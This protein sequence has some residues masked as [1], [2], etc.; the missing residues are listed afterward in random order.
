MQTQTRVEASA[1]LGCVVA[2]GTAALVAVGHAAW[3][4][5]VACADHSLLPDD[6]AADAALH[7]VAAVGGEVGELH[8]V[9]VPAWAQAG[10][11]GE[12]EGADG[13]AEGGDG[14]GRVEKL[15]LG[16]LEEGA[17][18]SAGREEVGVVAQDEF[19]EGGRGELVCSTAV[20]EAL[21]AYAHGSVNT[22]EKEEGSS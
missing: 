2:A 13:V 19:F 8:E 16:A 4:A 21:P 7:A 18:T 5:V 11:V 20:G 14:R 17:E 6:D 9:L 1:A 3:S 22:N 12:V 10:F 15:Q